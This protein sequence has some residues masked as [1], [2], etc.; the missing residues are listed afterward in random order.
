MLVC[1]CERFRSDSP[2]R[3]ITQ[4]V[5]AFRLFIRSHAITQRRI[6]FDICFVA[7]VIFCVQYLVRDRLCPAYPANGL[8]VVLGNTKES[9]WVA[10]EVL[11][12]PAFSFQAIF[13]GNRGVYQAVGLIEKTA[14]DP[15]CADWD[16]FEV[17]R[18]DLDILEGHVT[19]ALLRVA[20][21]SE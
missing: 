9:I 21:E 13:V 7:P 10:R 14:F 19:R 20:F 3:P 4:E 16:I 15:G 8:A 18:T 5:L 6:G 1:L 17:H 11:K 12:K 2:A